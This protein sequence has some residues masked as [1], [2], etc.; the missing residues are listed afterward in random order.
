MPKHEDEVTI[1]NGTAAW[2][3]MLA[4]DP[5]LREQTTRF[6]AAKERLRDGMMA[7]LEY[8]LQNECDWRD[9]HRELLADTTPDL[10][11]CAFWT[12]SEAVEIINI[13]K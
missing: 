8:Y 1:A 11:T 9:A 3:E 5:K 13:D 2:R 10:N 4:R 12:L 7:M 6:A